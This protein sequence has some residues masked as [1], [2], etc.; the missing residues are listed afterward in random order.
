MPVWTL[1]ERLD[2]EGSLEIGSRWDQKWVG[3]VF[4][5]CCDFF[6][7]FLTYERLLYASHCAGCF[8]YPKVSVILFY[9]YLL[10]WLCQ[11]LVVACRIF[12]SFPP[13]RIFSSSIG[14]SSLTRDQTPAP[15]IGMAESWPLNHQGSPT[16][17]GFELRKSSGKG[18]FQSEQEVFPFCT[19]SLTKPGASRS[20]D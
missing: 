8:S 10:I 9:I 20:G 14:S 13:R 11:V 4:S 2:Q 19:W 15:C 3:A 12:F 5:F 17:A 7:L 6:F 1:I 16:P 18:P